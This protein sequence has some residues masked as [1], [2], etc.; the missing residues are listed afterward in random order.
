MN[1]INKKPKGWY[2]QIVIRPTLSV[3][4]YENY[5]KICGYVAD[6]Y[7]SVDEPRLKEVIRKNFD[8]P[9]SKDTGILHS[10]TRH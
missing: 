1:K 5:E 8:T 2:Q 9:R 10:L 6:I 7:F 3:D 4:G